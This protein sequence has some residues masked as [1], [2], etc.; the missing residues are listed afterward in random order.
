MYV[1]KGLNVGEAPSP[2]IYTFAADAVVGRLGNRLG[3][4]VP[5]VALLS[6]DITICSAYLELHQKVPGLLHGSTYVPNTTP[7]LAI[8]AARNPQDAIDYAILAVLYGWMGASDDQ[9]IRN[10]LPPERVLSVDHGHFFNGGAPWNEAVFAKLGDATIHAAFVSHG[11]NTSEVQRA[12]VA[13]KNVTDEEIIEVVSC[14]P[15][16]WDVPDDD[17][18]ALAKFISRRRDTL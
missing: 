14:V 12:I 10:M 3:A 5:E 8:D 7:R 16:T 2:K 9:V 17:L 6:A 1:A 13:A 15:S 4:Q 11:A 18:V